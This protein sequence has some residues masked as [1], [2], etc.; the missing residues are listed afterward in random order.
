MN[1]TTYRAAATALFLAGI[2]ILG[3]QSCT[4]YID[5]VPDPEKDVTAWIEN[6]KQQRSFTYEYEMKT[7]AV[8]VR[9][10]GNCIMGWA[11]NIKG[12]WDYPG[13]QTDYSFEHI[14][15]NDI[16][17]TRK[18]SRWERSARGEESNIYL[19][20]LRMLDFDKFEYVSSDEGFN[21]RFK[22]NVPFLAP[23]R[24]KEMIG[25]LEISKRSYL[26]EMIWAGLPDS[27]VYWC[28][29]ISCFNKKK[30]VD[31]PVRDSRSFAIAADSAEDRGGLVRRIARRLKNAGVP[32]RLSVKDSLIYV[33]VPSTYKASDIAEILK[34]GNLKIYG[35]A[36]DR[37]SAHRVVN[38]QEDPAP[39]LLTETLL[40]S[41]RVARTSLAFDNRR[42]AYITFLV[43]RSAAELPEKVAVELDSTIIG[44]ATI[45][46]TKKFNKIVLYADMGYY[47]MNQIKSCID[48]MLPAL[49]VSQTAAGAD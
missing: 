18:D 42:R 14:G 24:W 34:P 39:V 48:Q 22:A 28:V 30:A 41:P 5:Y 7:Q 1:K 32:G 43:E 45:D 12:V 33:K 13:S 16:E 4:P 15:I 10:K 20:I 44:I 19:Q 37:E 49:K 36:P 21:Y 29:R 25:L 47:R 40:S 46:R 6:F 27:S 9:A 35:I 3:T 26:P 23:N 2:A 38:I 31:P 17:W 8:H 11:E